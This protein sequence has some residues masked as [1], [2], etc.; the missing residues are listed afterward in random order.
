[1]GSSHKE[2]KGDWKMDRE[3]HRKQEGWTL[4]LSLLGHWKGCL[5]ARSLAKEKDK[6]VASWPL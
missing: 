5:F 6:L 2:L 3:T 1:M 4:W